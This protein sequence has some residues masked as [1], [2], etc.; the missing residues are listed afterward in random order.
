M[1][2]EEEFLSASRVCIIIGESAVHR[3]RALSSQKPW[4]RRIEHGPAWM[5]DHF[6]FSFVQQLP[7]IFPGVK[8]LCT[9]ITPGKVLWMS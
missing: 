4:L 7:V 8:I 9:L 2:R 3:E 5:S 1:N 6:M